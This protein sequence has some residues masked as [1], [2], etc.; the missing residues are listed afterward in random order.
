MSH[1]IHTLMNG[2]LGFADLLSRMKL[3]P[4]AAR[5]A[6][7]IVRSGRSM[8]MLLNDILDI[9]KIESGKL[10]VANETF[11]LPQLIGDCERSHRAVPRPRASASP[12][13]ACPTCHASF[14][15]IR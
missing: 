4:E 8:M 14:A 1:E 13:Y 15:A 9:S 7:L 2:E 11:D 10:V 3:D 5:Y 12:Q 6:D